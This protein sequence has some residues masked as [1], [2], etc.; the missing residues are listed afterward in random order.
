[1]SGKIRL[2]KFISNAGISSRR[3]ADELISSGAVTINGKV[4][5]ELGVQVRAYEDLVT[6][7][8]ETI[9]LR[10]RF[11]YLLLNKPKDTITTTDDER[12]RKTVMDYVATTDR[13]YPIGRL[14]RN[15]TGVLLLTNDGEL[16]NRLTHP[17][18][19]IEREYHV[20]LDKR[21]ERE[22]AK[23]IAE[24]GID[25]GEGDITGKSELAVADDNPKDVVLLLREGK[26]RE[27][28]RI[29]ETLGYE[30]E[31]LDRTSFAGITHRGMSRGESRSLSNP[32]LHRLRKLA[33]IEE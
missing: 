16:T 22:D 28:R 4:V 9:S 23:R 1:M 11:I 19:E 25:I 15:T 32:E 20:T 5:T 8:G 26:N 7:N 24:G 29:F 31:K 27:V 33:G 13:V 10:P 3:K 2:N 12:D 18:F 21:L 17:S 30:V 14:D 6:V